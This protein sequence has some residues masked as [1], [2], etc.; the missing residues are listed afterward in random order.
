MH[1]N[2]IHADGLKA[3]FPEVSRTYLVYGEMCSRSSVAH[4][5]ASDTS[6]RSSSTLSSIS[7]VN[8]GYLT[9]MVPF[10]QNEDHLAYAHLG[11]RF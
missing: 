5:R 9:H 7:F 1:T 4:M 3:P 6:S 10:F 8:C 11:I 2:G